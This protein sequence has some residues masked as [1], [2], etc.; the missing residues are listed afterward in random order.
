MENYQA[1]FI[2]ICI[3]F[4]VYMTITTLLDMIFGERWRYAI[5]FVRYSDCEVCAET[6]FRVDA[7]KTFVMHYRYMVHCAHCQWQIDKWNTRGQCGHYP[8]DL[9]CV[10]Q[11]CY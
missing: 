5:G 8:H 2:V 4:T 7:R 3:G 6:M 1:W 10:T 11:E 9:D